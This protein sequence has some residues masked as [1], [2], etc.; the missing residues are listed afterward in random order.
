[1]PLIPAI[2]M[3]RFSERPVEEVCAMG[4]ITVQDFTQ[5][6]IYK[7]ILGIGLA[8]GEARGQARGEALGEARGKAKE[9]AAVTL[10][11]LNRRCGP[12]G[13]DT[14]ARIQALALEQLETL[15]EDLLDF[16]GPADL[17]AWLQPGRG[18]DQ[19]TPA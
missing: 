10:R 9:A 4:S 3:A 7:E 16:S 11:Q 13:A 12:L 5:T 6:P 2:L 19:P 18:G 14:T 1:M 8:E 17:A 15:A